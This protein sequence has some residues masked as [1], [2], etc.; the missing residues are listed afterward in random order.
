MSPVAHWPEC[1]RVHLDCAVARI[2]EQRLRLLQL[3]ALRGEADGKARR[4]TEQVAELRDLV[5]EYRRR[6]G[7]VGP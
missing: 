5:D 4:L 3:E 1:F 7:E 2:G 6:L